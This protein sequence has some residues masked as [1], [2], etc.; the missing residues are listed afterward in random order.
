MPPAPVVPLGAP[1][2]RPTEPVT[3]GAP[4]GPGPGIE[5]VA[6]PTGPDSD[7]RL[8]LGAMYQ[9][10]PTEEIRQLIEMLDSEPV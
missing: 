10:F 2:D 5:A 4:V 8:R 7:L 1:T 6:P 9:A 3:A